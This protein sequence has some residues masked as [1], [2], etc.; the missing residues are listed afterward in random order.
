MKRISPPTMKSRII[1][2]LPVLL[3]LLGTVNVP[4]SAGDLEKRYEAQTHLAAPKPENTENISETLVERINLERA[5]IHLNPLTED[6]R[7]SKAAAQHSRDMARNDFFSHRG[8]DGSMP[9][10]RVRRQGY[11]WTYVSEN[12]ICGIEGSSEIVKKWMASREHRNN[13]LSPLAVHIGIGRGADHQSKCTPYWTA[14][15]AAE[16]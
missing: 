4:V 6:A 16:K 11:N 3:A 15:F 7:L 9:E 5:R 13:I 12:V 14:L 8:F 2:F 1:T 10:K